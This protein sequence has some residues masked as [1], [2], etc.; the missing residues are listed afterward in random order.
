VTL[1]IEQCIVPDWPAPARVRGLQTTRIGGFSRAPYDT[2]NLGTHVDDDP[3]TVA[4]NRN[5]LNNLVPS[6]PIWL[7]QVH[8]TQVVLAEAA[9]CQPR[10]DAC[11]TRHSNT[12]CTVMTADCLPVLLCDGAA[13]V[14]GV[15]HAGW[16][17]LAAGVLESTAQAM[18]AAPSKLMAWLGPAIGPQSFE[19]GG[20]VRATFVS[21][22]K[23]AAAAFVAHG[24]KFLADIYL[25]ARLR[26][27]ALGVTQIFGGNFC[28]YQDRTRFFSYR[29]DGRTGR[30]ATMIWM[31]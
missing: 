29:R 28:T 10:G 4:S 3:L 20:E 9:G 13:T 21:Q 7:E 30:M 12:V 22:D 15:A 18:Q 11:I 16:R 6:E 5:L 2:L 31:A 27:H 25:L 26:L 23:A 17:G 1:R 24:D 14:V 8:G 19:V